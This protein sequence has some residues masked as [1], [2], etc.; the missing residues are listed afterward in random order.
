M[1]VRLSA[2]RDCGN[3][4]ANVV[5]SRRRGGGAPRLD[6]LDFA[7]SGDQ[8][9]R[10]RVMASSE[11]DSSP[12]TSLTGTSCQSSRGS[13]VQAAPSTRVMP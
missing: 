3:A 4:A 12:A 7:L 6:G 1:E 5:P 2:A 8:V 9:R 13:S 11:V 10:R